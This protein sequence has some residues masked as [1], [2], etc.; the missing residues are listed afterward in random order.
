MSELPDDLREAIERGILTR[1]QLS[2]LITLEAQ[3]IGLTAEE[4]VAHARAGT[5][6]RH[7]IAD[8]LALLVEMQAAA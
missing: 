5:L 8:D 2:Q 3:A 6:P 4:A 1:T 7:Y